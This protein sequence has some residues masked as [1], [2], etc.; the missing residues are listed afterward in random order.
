MQLRNNRIVVVLDASV[1]ECVERQDIFCV[2]GPGHCDVIHAFVGFFHVRAVCVE[3]NH[4]VEL[5]ALGAVNR[6]E[7]ERSVAL[8]VRLFELFVQS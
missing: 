8:C 4:V 2:H 7:N 5:K 6:G 1:L 3:H